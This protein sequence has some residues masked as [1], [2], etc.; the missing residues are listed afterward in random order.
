MARISSND[1]D[2]IDKLT[3]TEDYQVWKKQIKI[4]LRANSLLNVAE[5]ETEAAE[6]TTAWKTLDANAQTTII[7]T[8]DKKVF[9]NIMDCETA[10]EMWKKLQLIYERDSEQQK[11]KLLQDLYAYQFDKTVNIM[12]NITKV[13]GLAYM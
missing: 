9:V 6:R 10:P 5:N 3:C 7:T 4:I 2:H 11:Y 1:I 8:I 12:S 13:Q